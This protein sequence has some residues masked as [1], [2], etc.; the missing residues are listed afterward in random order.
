LLFEEVFDSSLYLTLSHLVPAKLVPQCGQQQAPGHA[1]SYFTPSDHGDIH[2][3][4]PLKS[5]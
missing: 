5:I 3:L 4:T 1:G 2:H